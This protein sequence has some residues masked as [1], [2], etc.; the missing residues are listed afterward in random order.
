[1]A[2]TILA[3][4]LNHHNVVQFIH[5]ADRPL[6]IIN[7]LLLMTITFV[8]YPTAL[9]AEAARLNVDD[10][11]F[12]ALMYSGTFVLVAI[13][14]NALWYI[15]TRQRRLIDDKIA[16]LAVRSVTMHYRL[17]VPLYVTAFLLAFVPVVGPTM[18][19]LIDASLALYFMFTGGIGAAP[20]RIFSR[21]RSGR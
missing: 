14:Y 18:S 16:Q 2:V 19:L 10:Q 13:F 5:H 8:N 21:L 11:Q 20:S 12:A 4:W 15:A 1:M 9:V 17:S 6:F 3:L 7:G